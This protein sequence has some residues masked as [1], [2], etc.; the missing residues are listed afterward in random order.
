MPDGKVYRTKGVN[1][2]T[3]T[4]L[5]GTTFYVRGNRL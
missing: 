4:G 5:S 2:Q 1:G 3:G